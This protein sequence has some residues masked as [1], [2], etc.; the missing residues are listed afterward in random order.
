LDDAGTELSFAAQPEHQNK[1]GDRCS[2]VASGASRSISRLCQTLYHCP[3]NTL[4][5][6]DPKAF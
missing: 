1:F 4:W 5:Q 6:A 3:R 2:T